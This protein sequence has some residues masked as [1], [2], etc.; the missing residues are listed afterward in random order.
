MSPLPDSLSANV[1]LGLLVLAIAAWVIVLLAWLFPRDK[2]NGVAKALADFKTVTTELASATINLIGALNANAD[3]LEGATNTLTTL[4]TAATN[5]GTTITAAGTLN[6]AA[7][8]FP[9]PPAPPPPAPMP[10]P[11]VPIRLAA[12]LARAGRGDADALASLAAVDDFLAARARAPA[13]APAPALPGSEAP[14]GPGNRQ[15]KKPKTL[16]RRLLL[17]DKLR[18][19][20]KQHGFD[21]FAKSDIY[22]VAMAA[23]LKKLQLKIRLKAQQRAPALPPPDNDD[24]HA[25]P[26]AWSTPVTGVTERTTSPPAAG[27][28][29]G[30]LGRSALAGGC[31]LPTYE[32]ITNAIIK[33]PQFPKEP[34]GDVN[35]VISEAMAADL[36]RPFGQST[37]R[38]F[39]FTRFKVQFHSRSVIMRQQD[40]WA[41]AMGPGHTATLQ[42]LY[43]IGHLITHI[44]RHFRWGDK[45]P[46]LVPHMPS[47]GLDQNFGDDEVTLRQITSFLLPID[48]LN[49][50]TAP[51]LSAK[52][53]IHKR[54]RCALFHFHGAGCECPDSIAFNAVRSCPRCNTDFTVSVTPDTVSAG[55]EGRLLVFTTWKSLGNG[56]PYPGDWESHLTSSPSNRPSAHG[57]NQI[58]FEVWPRHDFVYKINLKEIQQRVTLV[59]E[60]RT[61]RDAP[62]E[63]TAAAGPASLPTQG[64]KEG[65]GWE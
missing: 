48:A 64:E 39:S 31:R 12:L 61:Q 49:G 16:T 15:P 32:S 5:I 65:S 51:L 47:F 18:A 11:G 29:P 22:T 9:A 30:P 4:N 13:P 45:Y 55:P 25:S 2:D 35:P 53:Y 59:R 41:P 62:P 8:A 20:P 10:P 46:F 21:N 56:K 3:N 37:G 27:P 23:A 58:Y 19:R 17:E 54:L 14:G 44:C 24:G 1:T 57:L 26:A 43:E 36:A 7:R 42:T 6:A 50:H 33:T 28:E 63:H 52:E 60:S 40:V 34:C 38:G